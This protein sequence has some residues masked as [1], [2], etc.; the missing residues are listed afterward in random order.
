MES[1]RSASFDRAGD[2]DEL[3]EERDRVGGWA[4]SSGTLSPS[5]SGS[6]WPAAGHLFVR[7]RTARRWLTEQS[8]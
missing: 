2:N 6:E 5:G 8:E 1:T 4:T 3:R 7:E